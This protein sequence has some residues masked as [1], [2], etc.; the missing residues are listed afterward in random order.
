MRFV[1]TIYLWSRFLNATFF[2]K[3]D[4]DLFNSW[5]LK[6][7]VKAVVWQR[8]Y[9]LTLPV[10]TYTYDRNMRVLDELYELLHTT[11][12]LVACHSIH[13]IHYNAMLLVVGLWSTCNSVHYTSSMSHLY[14]RVNI[15]WRLKFSILVFQTPFLLVKLH[16]VLFWK[17][18]AKK[19]KNIFVATLMNTQTNP[20]PCG[21]ATPAKV[22]LH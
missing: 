14:S 11:P 6:S 12:I 17:T 18:H 7:E 13:L 22:H 9:L 10:I 2:N 15:Y 19:Y 16:D 3:T 1:I 5:S 21:Y 20:T 4:L 8:F